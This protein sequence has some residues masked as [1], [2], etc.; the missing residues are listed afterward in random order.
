MCDI[1][2]CCRNFMKCCVGIPFLKLQQCFYSFHETLL[3]FK[4]VDNQSAAELPPFIKGENASYIVY[5]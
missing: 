5:Y 1:F 2:S 3:H 4:M